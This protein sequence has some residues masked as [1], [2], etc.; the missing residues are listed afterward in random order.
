MFYQEPRFNYITMKDTI[1]FNGMTTETPFNQQYI[2]NS[3][4]KSENN[5]DS[6]QGFIY[7]LKRF[8]KKQSFSITL[9]EFLYWTFHDFTKNQL[10]VNL[11]KFVNYG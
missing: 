6:S 5:G 7:N 9:D 3:N 1:A 4:K 2:R 8:H 11:W 10:I